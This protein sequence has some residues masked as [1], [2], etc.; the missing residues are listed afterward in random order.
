MLREVL[1]NILKPEHKAIGLYL[2]EDADMVFLCRKG[3]PLPV[4]VFTQHVLLG[5]ILYEADQELEWQ[6]S[7]ITFEKED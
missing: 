6:K 5:E 2:D 1:D 7:G 3:E 4:A